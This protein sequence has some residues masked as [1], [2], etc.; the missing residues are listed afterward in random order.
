MKTS[1]LVYVGTVRSG[2]V[3]WSSPATALNRRCCLSRRLR[4]F[5]ASARAVNASFRV[6]AGSARAGARVAWPRNGQ[7]AGCLC[8]GR[9]YHRCRVPSLVIAVRRPI[10][11][12]QTRRSSA[13]A[14]RNSVAGH[15][16]MVWAMAGSAQ[17]TTVSILLFTAARLIFRRTRR[18]SS[19]A[20]GSK[21][22]PTSFSVVCELPV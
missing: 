7:A 10:C 2:W 5:C 17:S 21:I 18:V 19:R 22:T 13:F 15:I 4:G 6:P 14:T 12:M 1:V 16:V 8:S 9:S 3:P 20:I 11:L